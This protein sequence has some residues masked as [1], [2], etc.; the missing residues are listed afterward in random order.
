MRE[1]KPEKEPEREP[2]VWTTEEFEYTFSE[3]VRD[4]II[5]IK[6]GYIIGFLVLVIAAAVIAYFCGEITRDDLLWVVGLA[7]GL[8]LLCWWSFRPDRPAKDWV[9]KSLCSMDCD[10][11]YLVSAKGEREFVPWESIV[12]VDRRKMSLIRAPGYDV[13]CCFRSLARQTLLDMSAARVVYDVNLVE[14]YQARDEVVTIGYTKS[15]MKKIRAYWRQ[16]E[17]NG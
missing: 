16:C 7:V 10:G 8:P 2:A 15:R 3:K 6:T 9:K 13:I 12:A 1:K 14:F 5:Q 11:I 17:E 4:E